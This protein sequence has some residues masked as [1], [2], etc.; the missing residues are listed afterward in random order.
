MDVRIQTQNEKKE[1]EAQR[2]FDISF[3]LFVSCDEIQI[4]PIMCE[5]SQN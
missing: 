2:R 3:S 1:T 4:Y 5:H